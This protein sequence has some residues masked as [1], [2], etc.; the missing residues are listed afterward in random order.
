LEWVAVHT[1]ASV[2]TGGEKIGEFVE[3]LVFMP[4]SSVTLL[5]SSDG[6]TFGECVKTESVVHELS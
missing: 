1:Q 4:V 2:V 3:E 6:F 5:Q